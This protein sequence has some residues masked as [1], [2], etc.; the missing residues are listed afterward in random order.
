MA[1]QDFL[2]GRWAWVRASRGSTIATVVV[3]FLLLYYSVGGWLVA[4]IDPDPALRPT[5]SQLPPGGSVTAAMA[6]RLIAHEVDDDH[7]IPNDSLLSRTAWLDNKPAYQ[8]GLRGTV[9]TVVAPLGDDADIQAAARALAVPSD[10]WWLHGGWPFVGGSAESEYRDAVDALVRYNA[11]LAGR[12]A[13]LDRSPQHLAAV[14]DALAGR[15]DAVAGGVERAIA[16]RPAPHDSA[17]DEEF[18]R[19]RG[20]AY[21]ASMLLRAIKE[22]QAALVRSQQ[23]ALV[24]NEATDALDRA[25]DVH[26][27][28]V[29]RADLTEQGYYLL[30]ARNK[31]KALS[32]AVGGRP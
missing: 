13:A 11:R 26:P 29:G 25:V 2:K 14:L 17:A 4:G 27:A 24:W 8:D 21:A 22:D 32:A 12:E 15:L 1:V 9:A 7:W 5:A 31:L 20:S 6:A 19:V 3:A 23:L 30:L 18:Y 10:R 28:I 16:G